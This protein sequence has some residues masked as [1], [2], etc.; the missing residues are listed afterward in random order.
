MNPL[1]AFGLP[2]GPDMIVISI[3]VLV[4]F[5]AKKLPVF[6]R[7]LGRSMGEF[8]KAK[9]EFESELNS[10]AD[11]SYKAPEKRIETPKVAEANSVKQES[12]APAKA[13]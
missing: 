11:E 13:D 7:S 9:E 10:A 8:R 12:A 2:S 1:L 3:L 6:A 4:L 5:G